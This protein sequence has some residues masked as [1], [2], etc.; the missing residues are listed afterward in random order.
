MRVAHELCKLGSFERDGTALAWL[1]QINAQAVRILEHRQA[2][3]AALVASFWRTERSVI[4]ELGI[5]NW[6]FAFSV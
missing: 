3:Q 6:E 4:R 5:G 1:G 2:R